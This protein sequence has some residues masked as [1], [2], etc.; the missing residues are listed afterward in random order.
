MNIPGHLYERSLFGSEAVGRNQGTEQESIM[1]PNPPG[2]YF[3]EQLNTP[4]TYHTGNLHL[5]TTVQGTTQQETDVTGPTR[6]VFPSTT[7]D[8]SDLLCWESAAAPEG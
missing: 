3:Q 1:W 4:M 6:E 2:I 5:R 8:T 7:Q